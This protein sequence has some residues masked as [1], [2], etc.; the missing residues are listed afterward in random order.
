MQKEFNLIERKAS[1]GIIIKNGL[2][3]LI[4]KKNKNE[5]KLPGGGIEDN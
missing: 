4:N 1:R 2:V 3:A 5:Y